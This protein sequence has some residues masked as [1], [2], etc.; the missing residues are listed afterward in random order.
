[1]AVSS[2]ASAQGGASPDAE[3]ALDEIVVTAQKRA[4][5]LQD[6]PISVQA[7]TGEMLQKMGVQNF[8]NFEVP[9][10]PGRSDLRPSGHG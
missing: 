4:E 9:G 8:E 2:L 3:V 7:V 6:V 5:R 1:M 10:A